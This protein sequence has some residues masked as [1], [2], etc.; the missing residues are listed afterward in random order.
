[1]SFR[2]RVTSRCHSLR[3]DHLRY[4]P[5][6]IRYVPSVFVMSRRHLLR[7]VVFVTYRLSF[8]TCRLST[9]R[10]YCIRY[11]PLV[12]RYVSIVTYR[13][14]RTDH[15]VPIPICI[16]VSRRACCTVIRELPVMFGTCGTQST[17]PEVVGIEKMRK[18]C[19]GN[20]CGRKGT[21]RV[22]LRP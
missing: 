2:R 6:C 7:T 14:L 21:L 19:F 1:M 17:H 4:V 11:V 22:T 8:V 10:I 13:S 20:L 16:V 15:C 9:L 5:N 12:D 3:V 18:V